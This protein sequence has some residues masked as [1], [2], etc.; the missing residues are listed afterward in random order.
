MSPLV[1]C[2]TTVIIFFLYHIINYARVNNNSINS[3]IYDYIAKI[4]RA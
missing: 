2:H 4:M 3:I 1:S